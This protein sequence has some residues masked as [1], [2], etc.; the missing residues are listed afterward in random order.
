VG[1]SHLDQLPIYQHAWQ[2]TSNVDYF[3]QNVLLINPYPKLVPGLTNC[4]LLCLGLSTRIGEG[5]LVPFT[6]SPPRDYKVSPD[7]RQ[8]LHSGTRNHLELSL[9]GEV[10][11]V[12]FSD[13]V[14]ELNVVERGRPELVGSWK[15]TYKN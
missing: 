13:N 5:Q 9:D 11:A 8:F 6:W 3:W 2:H 1:S 12:V 4:T 15:C 7:F 14:V 10:L